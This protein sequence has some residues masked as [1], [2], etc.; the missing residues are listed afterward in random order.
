MQILT[1]WKANGHVFALAIVALLFSGGVTHA[2]ASDLSWQ[3]CAICLSGR[4][5]DSAIS[6]AGGNGR[7]EAL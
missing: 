7:Y 6:I 2:V 5:S 1:P 3:G 4:H